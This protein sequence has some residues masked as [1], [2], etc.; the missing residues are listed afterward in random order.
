MLYSEIIAV[1]S[2]TQTKH[3]NTLCGQNVPRMKHSQ[4]SP[5]YT[6]HRHKLCLHNDPPIK[7]TPS[8]L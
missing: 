3:K 6:Q 4:S 7:H 5:I 1:C 8:R 2:Q